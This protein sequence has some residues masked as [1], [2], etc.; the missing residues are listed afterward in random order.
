MKA[1]RISLVGLALAGM[2]QGV[3][4]ICSSHTATVSVENPGAV[5]RAIDK[6]FNGGKRTKEIAEANKE[7]DTLYATAHYCEGQIRRVADATTLTF[8]RGPSWK[9]EDTD[10]G[11]AVTVWGEDHRRSYKVKCYASKAGQVLRV[12]MD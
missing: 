3:W 1:L 6:I 4:G 11:F 7:C 10:S 9:H 12:L 8:S 5:E 2:C